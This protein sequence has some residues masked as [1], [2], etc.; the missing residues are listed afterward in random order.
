[1]LG[2]GEASRL[3]YFV[4][5][6]FTESFSI[7]IRLISERQNKRLSERRKN[8]WISVQ[9]ATAVTLMVMTQD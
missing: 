5:A 1:M 3:F 7:Y 6:E 4:P 2:R 8:Q 9:V